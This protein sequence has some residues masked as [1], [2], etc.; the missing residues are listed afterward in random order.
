[1]KNKIKKIE[2]REI[3]DSRGVPT[4]EVDLFVENNVFRSSVPSGSS[5][6]EHE[7]FE[8]RDLLRP[9][10]GTAARRRSAGRGHRGGRAGTPSRPGA[11]GGS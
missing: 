1:M 6:G 11:R 10:P 3:L 9:L 7:A 8:L 4:L 5:T 2:A